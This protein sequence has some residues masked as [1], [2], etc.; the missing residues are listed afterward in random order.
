MAASALQQ[1]TFWKSQR[2]FY[3][4]T[5]GRSEF[6]FGFHG[7]AWLIS[8]ALFCCATFFVSQS[9]AMAPRPAPERGDWVVT[10][11]RT[12]R[13]WSGPPSQPD[14]NVVMHG[15]PRSVGV[16][17]GPVH[18]F[19]HTHGFTAVLI[20]HPD[21]EHTLVWMNIWALLNKA[22][23]AKGVAFAT[24]ASRAELSEWRNAGWENRFLD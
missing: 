8:A 7:S 15:A 5:F 16:Y 10:A 2:D 1:E 18:E 21:L 17:L 12:C 19:V 6:N 9:W 13:F 11:I 3:Q 4:R 24:L 22:K 23:V 14:G 20:P